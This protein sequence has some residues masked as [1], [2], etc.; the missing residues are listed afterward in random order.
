MPLIRTVAA[1]LAFS[2]LGRALPAAAETFTVLTGEWK[3]YVSSA[4]PGGGPLARMVREALESQGHGLE[5]RF[6]PWPRQEQNVREG[7]A[8]ATFP[9]SALAYYSPSLFFSAPLA[10]HRMVFFY[11]PSGHPGFDFIG[12]EDLKRYRLGAS[13][14]YEYVALFDEASI[15]PDYGPD[16]E[17]SLRKLLAGRVDL[18]PESEAVGWAMLQEKF[19]A[20]SGRVAASA[21]ALYTEDLFVAV[22]RE[23]PDAG[24]FLDALNSGLDALTV[25]GRRAE[26]LREGGLQTAPGD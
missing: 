7:H 14:G 23:H 13:R 16:L 24:K 2:L 22:S 5:L 21:T 25:S 6:E 18:V 12:M 20:E 19:P 11:L 26:L 10:R 4:L 15:K 3:P 1:L 9:W 17:S 8:L